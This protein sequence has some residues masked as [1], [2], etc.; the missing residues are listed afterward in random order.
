MRDRN[1]LIFNCSKIL[2]IEAEN[3]LTKIIYIY[4]FDRMREKLSEYAAEGAPW[5]LAAS[6]LDPV[7]LSIVCEGPAQILE[8]CVLTTSR[9]LSYPS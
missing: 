5:P 9:K 3:C 7:R 2:T 6:I 1:L 4:E 8:V